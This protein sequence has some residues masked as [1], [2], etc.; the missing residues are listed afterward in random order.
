MLSMFETKVPGRKFTKV[1]LIN[2]SVKGNMKLITCAWD[3]Q[4]VYEI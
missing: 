3:I 4:N 1:I 2:L